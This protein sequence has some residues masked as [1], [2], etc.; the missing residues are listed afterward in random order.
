MKTLIFSDCHLGEKFDEEK[1][2]FL[3]KIIESVDRV[4][5]NGDFWEGY[6]MTFD[7]FIESKWN[8]LFPALLKKKAVYIYGN[9]DKKE[10][11]NKKLNLFSVKQTNRYKFASG[12]KTF[13]VEHGDRIAPLLDIYF[14]PVPRFILNRLNTIESLV[15]KNFGKKILYYFYWNQSFKIKKFVKKVYKKNEFFVFGHIPIQEVDL[16]N[17]YINSGFIKHG[18]GQYLIVDGSTI[19]LYEEWYDR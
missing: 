16:K 4:I 9:H 8:L 5:I 2:R 14:H 7:S 18:V 19:N 17:H 1:Y 13:Y 3:K 12:E 15:T 10:F 6:E 11:A